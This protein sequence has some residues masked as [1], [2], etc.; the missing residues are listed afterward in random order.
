[1]RLASFAGFAVLRS[2]ERLAGFAILENLKK[3]NPPRTYL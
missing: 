1:M 3:N 2:L